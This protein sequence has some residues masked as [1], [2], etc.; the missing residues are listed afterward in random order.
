MAPR[1]FPLQAFY[2]TEA[3]Q[4]FIEL[5]L[6]ESKATKDGYA[7]LDLGAGFQLLARYSP[8]PGTCLRVLTVGIHHQGKPWDGDVAARL[9]ELGVAEGALALRVAE[10]DDMTANGHVVFLA[11]CREKSGSSPNAA[12]I[13]AQRIQQ[14][15]DTLRELSIDF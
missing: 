14:L 4:G 7:T 15:A 6:P 3:N 12:K 2:A 11:K 9:R 13:Q 10:L 8:I 1:R 5:E